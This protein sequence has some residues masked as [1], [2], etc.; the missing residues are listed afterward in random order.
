MCRRRDRDY[1]CHEENRPYGSCNGKFVTS[2]QEC[3][4]DSGKLN[5]YTPFSLY[6][7]ARIF[8]QISRFNP[9]DDDAN[10]SV[11]FLLAA[12]VAVKDSNPLAESY[13]L[14]LDLEGTGLAS[15]QENALAFSDLEKGMVSR[16]TPPQGF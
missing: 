16:R 6:V 3:F 2:P 4:A 14:Q 1:L 13:L 15:L 12:L 11:R 9:G 5:V 8:A 10:S 7:A